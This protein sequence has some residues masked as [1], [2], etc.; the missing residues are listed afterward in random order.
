MPSLSR[1]LV[2]ASH[3]VELD[4]LSEVQKDAFTVSMMMYLQSGILPK[5]ERL[6]QS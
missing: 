3:V 5:I 1:N 2:D 6:M 4:F